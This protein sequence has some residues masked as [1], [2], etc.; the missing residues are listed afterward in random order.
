VPAARARRGRGRRR[1]RGVAHGGGSVAAVALGILRVPLGSFGS[2]GVDRGG[3]GGRGGWWCRVYHPPLVPRGSRQAR[4]D[5]APP[6][7]LPPSTRPGCR[8]PGRAREG[9]GTTTGPSGVGSPPASFA[10]VGAQSGV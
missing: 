2:F 7:A 4:H 8:P 5:A 1:G 10:L 6:P 3:P 9:R